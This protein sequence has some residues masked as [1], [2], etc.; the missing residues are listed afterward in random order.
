MAPK[1]TGNYMADI[2]QEDRDRLRSYHKSVRVFGVRKGKFLEFE[3]TMGCEEL[4]I[5]LVMPYPIFKEFCETNHVAE[6]DC[7]V[8]VKAEFDR[9]SGG[10][11]PNLYDDTNIIK[12][13][14][15]K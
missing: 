8:G 3:F 7:A 2:K 6:I 5:E 4:T 9:L 11:L 13:G 1:E 14:D 10:A 15:F 12:L